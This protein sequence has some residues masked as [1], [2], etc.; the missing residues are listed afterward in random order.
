MRLAIPTLLAF[1]AVILGSSGVSEAA[2]TTT[3]SACRSDV[4]ISVVPTWARVGFSQA[5]PR[6]PY[7]LGKSGNIVA[8]LW[9][10]HNALVSPPL[11][12]RN[13][14]ILWVARAPLPVDKVTTFYIRAQRMVGTHDMGTPVSRIVRGGPGPSI[15]NLPAAGCWRLALHWAGHSDSLDVR[16]APNRS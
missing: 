2:A 7:A 15:I 14:K 4:H 10:P 13:N 11:K 6:M 3:T 9:A 1:S 8:I 5:K 16:Y 12:D